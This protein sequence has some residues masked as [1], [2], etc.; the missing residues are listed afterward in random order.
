MLS[1]IADPGT[2]GLINTV[3]V[4]ALAAA[5]GLVF[6]VPDDSTAAIV[7]QAVGAAT[8]AGAGAAAFAGASFLEELQK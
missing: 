6:A 4:V 5:A 3:G 7:A 2:P 8:L 1:L